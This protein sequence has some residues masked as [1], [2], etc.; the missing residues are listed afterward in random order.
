MQPHII[1]KL[2]GDEEDIYAEMGLDVAKNLKY[3]LSINLT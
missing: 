3:Q 2:E 1:I